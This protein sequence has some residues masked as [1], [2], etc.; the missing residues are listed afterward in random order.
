M[1][2]SGSLV[3]TSGRAPSASRSTSTTASF[4]LS[5]TNPEWVRA[6]DET[7]ASTARVVRTVSQSCQ[8][9]VRAPW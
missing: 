4:T 9:T 5:A 2:T 8:A 6:E 3:S 1:R 7:V